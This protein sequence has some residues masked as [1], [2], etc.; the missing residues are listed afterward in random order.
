MLIAK[1]LPA[2]QV[3]IP[4]SSALL[5]ALSS[6]PNIARALSVLAL[7][8]NSAISIYGI[9]ILQNN[10]S[11]NFGNW[12]PPFGIEYRLDHLNQPII[13]YINCI[14]L[15]C[16]TAGHYFIQE[17]IIKFIPN[18]R[19][20]LFYAILLF[21]HAGYIG[22]ISTNDLFNLYVFIEISSLSTYVLMATGGNPR[23]VIGAFNYLMLG[24]IGATLIL[25]GIGFILSQTGSLNILDIHQRLTGLYDSKIVI[26]A[27][28]FVL[29]GVLLKIAF[30]PMH[31]WMVRAYSS[32]PASILAYLGSIST[33][34]GSYICI[35]F[36]YFVI[37]DQQ[38]LQTIANFI[39]PLAL[40]TIILVSWF[41]TISVNIKKIVI[42]G[43]AAGVG[44]AMLLL[45]IASDQ[46]SPILYQ[47][48]FI[49]GLNKAGLFL[50]IAYTEI[51][52]NIK[53]TPLL[54]TAIIGIIFC[55]SGLPI[56]P[57]FIIKLKM[58]DLLINYGKWLEFFIVIIGSTLS[59][60]YHYRIASLLFFSNVR[61]HNNI[62]EHK[63]NLYA[64]YLIIILQLIILP[65]L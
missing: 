22:I 33:I 53:K 42:Y 29:I 10:I 50:I 2:L 7:I 40:V 36:I 27:I 60:L 38:Q 47:L 15:F 35:R 39:T 56:S 58:L 9:L 31:F 12:Q 13:I 37:E 16:L 34:V 61:S 55:S 54:Y 65:L 11:Y 19:Q 43:A 8:L 25:I 46:I 24:T 52:S 41:A 28:S 6:K 57:M 21:A 18:N 63:A 48:L 23:A 14:L 49:D 59:L 20:H 64:F 44:Y 32:T 45:T 17:S 1:H 5:A 51:N 4:F 3:L 62:E 30:F 26:A